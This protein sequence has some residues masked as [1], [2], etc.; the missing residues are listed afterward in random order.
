MKDDV[1]SDGG[2]AAPDMPMDE[3]VAKDP[4]RS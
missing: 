1:A 3:G 4:G 2:G